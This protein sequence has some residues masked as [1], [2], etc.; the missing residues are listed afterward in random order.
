MLKKSK[1]LTM[2]LICVIL[3]C[4]LLSAAVAIAADSEKTL[5]A[6]EALCVR[7]SSAEE[8]KQYPASNANNLTRLDVRLGWINNGSDFRSFL[9]FDLAPIIGEGS[10]DDV[11]IKEVKLLLTSHADDGATNNDDNSGVRVFPIADRYDNNTPINFS[12]TLTYK[13]ARE[14]KMF[15]MAALL[16]N[17]AALTNNTIVDSPN[18]DNTYQLGSLIIPNAKTEGPSTIQRTIVLD[19]MDFINY[20]KQSYAAFADTKISLLLTPYVGQHGRYFYSNGAATDSLKPK[21]Y[22]KYSEKPSKLEIYDVKIT[23]DNKDAYITKG[24]DIK[25]QISGINGNTNTEYVS[26]I[27]AFYDKN[28]NLIQAKST[29]K[30]F[31]ED[32]QFFGFIK[33]A[34]N[35]LVNVPS[36]TS[37]IKAFVFKSLDSAT[38]LCKFAKVETKF[39]PVTLDVDSITTLRSDQPATTESQTA[40]GDRF[41]VRNDGTFRT[42]LNF[43][44]N[45]KF[46][47]KSVNEI[48]IISVEL[49][50]YSH[51]T[52]ASTGTSSFVQVY[53]AVVNVG[54]EDVNLYTLAW[55][56]DLTYT[57]ANQKG[58]FSK[59]V[60]G[61]LLG[62]KIVSTTLNTKYTI[63]IDKDRFAQSLANNGSTSLVLN[64]PSTDNKYFSRTANPPKLIINYREKN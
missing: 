13:H 6:D 55:Y 31:I 37:S 27:V 53:P 59:I 47:G 1:I 7:G 14:N 20:A 23:N 12:N 39:L 60:S 9:K 61:S 26:V 28:N 43:D 36:N 44:L 40:Y 22:I 48:E 64:T 10:L 33:F 34:G 45:S 32:E 35:E 8:T 2:L 42:L 21:L 5:T 4:T 29:I 62:E 52:T 57:T 16:N 11:I 58:L 50:L 63:K 56:K 49:E 51:Q 54:V 24:T 38:P 25:V 18:D 3:T 30:E 19:T 41:D 17:N 46:D 15:S